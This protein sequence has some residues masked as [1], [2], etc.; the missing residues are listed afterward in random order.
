MKNPSI[1]ARTRYALLAMALAVSVA[2]TNPTR[3]QT[4]AA[5]APEPAPLVADPK[6]ATDV[7]EAPIPKP[8]PRPP[9]DV[10]IEIE[11]KFFEIP[12]AVAKKLGLCPS[13]AFQVRRLKPRTSNWQRVRLS[14][15][16]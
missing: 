13:Q 10:M 1:V 9:K 15:P 2:L 5:V 6:P 12:E 4:P 8:A 11:S 3:A 16:P 14:S 7:A